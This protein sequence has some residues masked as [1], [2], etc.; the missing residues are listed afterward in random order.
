M[1]D[2]LNVRILTPKALIF[3]GQA[4]SVSSTNSDGRFDILPEHANFITLVENAPIDIQGR[5]KQFQ[6]FQFSQ[7]II[8]NYKN[9]ISIF[10]EPNIG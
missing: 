3:E 8:Y 1:N 10:A 9:Q 2:I 5:D 7:A 4:L 6:S